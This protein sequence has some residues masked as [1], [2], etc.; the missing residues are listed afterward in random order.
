MG[1][2]P[3]VAIMNRYPENIQVG[4]DKSLSDKMAAWICEL[5]A[6][7]CGEPLSN[8]GLY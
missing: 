8:I 4:Q 7:K 2:E 6:G 1:D 5:L 3:P